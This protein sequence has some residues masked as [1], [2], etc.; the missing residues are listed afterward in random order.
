MSESIE[1][2][3]LPLDT[4]KEML[5]QV[6]QA[7]SWDEALGMILDAVHASKAT[8]SLFTFN[9]LKVIGENLPKIEKIRKKI[10]AL[11]T[12]FE[13][14]EKRNRLCAEKAELVG[15]LP[16]DYDIRE[17]VARV[18]EVPGENIDLVYERQDRERINKYK[19]IESKDK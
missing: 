11:G 14:D 1:K 2:K 12:T 15:G 16:K 8:E 10:D 9:Q 17:I 4:F 18:T 7:T 6:P 13:D 19:I 3:S 5:C